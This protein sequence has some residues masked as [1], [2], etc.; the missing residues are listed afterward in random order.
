MKHKIRGNLMPRIR[1]ITTLLIL[2]CTNLSSVMYSK[3]LSVPAE[4]PTIQ[5]AILD[6]KDFDTVLI[7]PGSYRGNGNRDLV[8]DATY[9]TVCGN[10]LP[11]E[12]VIDAEGSNNEY[13][14]GF[15]IN[16]YGWGHVIFRNLSITNGVIDPQ[17]EYP[18]NRGA[19]ILI[20]NCGFYAES[21]ILK[22]NSAYSGGAIYSNS[23]Y[24]KF[25]RCLF[26]DNVSS[27]NGGAIC[28]AGLEVI[29]CDFSSNFAR[30]GGAIYS[31]SLIINQSSFLQNTAVRNGGAITSYFSLDITQT[32]FF[33]NQGS[34]Y[35]G[36]INFMG[37][38]FYMNSC[39]LSEN[40]GWRGGA[41]CI[42]PDFQVYAKA[43]IINSIF[44]QN[45]VPDEFSDGGGLYVFGIHKTLIDSCT[46]YN[47]SCS[48]S[49]GAIKIE[50]CL[51]GTIRNSIFAENEAPLASDIYIADKETPP[52]AQECK[53]Y[54]GNCALREDGVTNDAESTQLVL[55]D[56]IIYDSPML[57][58]PEAGNF[59]LD[60]C[61]PC[62]DMGDPQ[63]SSDHDYN[64]QPR[65]IGTRN[66][67]GALECQVDLSSG[68]YLF[69]ADPFLETGDLFKLDV[70]ARSENDHPALVIALEIDGHFWF[71]PDW[72]ETFEY[73][74]IEMNYGRYFQTVF[75]FQWPEL[76]L[77]SDVME[78]W[79][80]VMDP[81]DQN[82]WGNVSVV[83]WGYYEN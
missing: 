18:F 30:Y 67:I 58:S 3:T 51:D 16:G 5:A 10:G 36:A 72:S 71:F 1:C 21:C 64:M 12:I 53:I 7:A 55:G 83:P 28:S 25:N 13:H 70:L 15:I 62:I 78:F 52:N 63:F 27:D 54:I 50:Y 61:S 23:F 81:D 76:S 57:I 31:Y 69:L 77:G 41:I 59:E 19:A 9:L 82:I 46:F 40:I 60:Y 75:D 44:D 37:E 24:C 6:A 80:C 14:R 2:L 20:D 79:A 4:Y 48:G 74:P 56:T 35:G 22:N 29:A 26:K 8:I 39:R 38:R 17:A 45:Y 33:Q 32:L 73:L 42:I 49:G 47:N 43:E 65:N 66:D 34:G 68:A 11:E